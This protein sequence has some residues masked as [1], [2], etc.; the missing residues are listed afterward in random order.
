[1]DNHRPG[2]HQRVESFEDGGRDPVPVDVPPWKGVSQKARTLLFGQFLPARLRPWPQP[3]HQRP[4]AGTL[5]HLT[6]QGRQQSADRDNRR[7][8]QND[9]RKRRASRHLLDPDRQAIERRRRRD[10]LE[11]SSRH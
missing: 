7:Q 10:E 11:R 3:V 1:M 5:T 4:P 8:H 6:A 9:A 2:S